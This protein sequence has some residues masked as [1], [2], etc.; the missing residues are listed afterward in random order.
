MKYYFS[1]LEEEHCYELSY[2]Y[3]L[4]EENNLKELK[5]KPAVPIHG[6]GLFWCKHYCEVGE[7]NN[8]TCGKICPKYH[9][10]N[11]KNGI[12]KNWSYTYRPT[13]PEIKITL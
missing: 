13:T 4:M 6:E 8:G 5:L 11:G 7:S 1:E 10:R 3:D 2:F 12:C 9:P